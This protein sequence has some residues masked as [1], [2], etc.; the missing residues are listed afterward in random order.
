MSFPFELI[1]MVGST[2][3]SGVM[4]MMAQ[5]M[6]AKQDYQKILNEIRKGYELPEVA[7]K[8]KTR[9]GQIRK[10]FELATIETIYKNIIGIP[11]EAN[12]KGVKAIILRN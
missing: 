6:K 8:Y 9:T 12:I 10:N 2:L 7:K 11:T 5:S 1:T 3:L 4:S